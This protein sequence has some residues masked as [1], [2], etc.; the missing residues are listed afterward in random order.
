MADR[1]EARVPCPRCGGAIHPVA[2]KCKHC[3]A[4]LAA[5]RVGKPQAA[6]ALPKLATPAVVAAPPPSDQDI[7]SRPADRQA[8]PAPYA[9]TA[10]YAGPPSSPMRAIDHSSAQFAPVGGHDDESGP[11]PIL[12]PRPTGRMFIAQPTARWPIVVI[13]ISVLAIL[14]SI[15]ALAR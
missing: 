1:P 14:L 10:P 9:P 7:W 4:D 11:V 8:A 5:L 6:A 13:A 12:P 3:K 15:G 2:G